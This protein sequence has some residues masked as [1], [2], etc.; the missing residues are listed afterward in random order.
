M[1]VA[2]LMGHGMILQVPGIFGRMTP[3]F[4]AVNGLANSVKIVQE[5]F[6]VIEQAGSVKAE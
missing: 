2:W 1:A 5:I 4:C 3:G 6:K